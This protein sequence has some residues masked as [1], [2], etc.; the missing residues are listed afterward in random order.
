MNDT[1]QFGYPAKP[2]PY[3]HTDGRHISLYFTPSVQPRQ[4]RDGS[5]KLLLSQ[6]LLPPLSSVSVSVSL[7]NSM[8]HTTSKS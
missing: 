1:K 2:C 4:G 6:L 8:F 7:F 5:S 3:P